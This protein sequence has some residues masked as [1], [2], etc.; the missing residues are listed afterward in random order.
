VSEQDRQPFT[1]AVVADSADLAGP[2]Q[3]LAN[4]LGL[5]LVSHPATGTTT[6]PDAVLRLTPAGLCLARTD[7]GAPA[8]LR[9]DFGSA[10]M[11]HRRRGGQ[12]ELLGRAV[13]VGK[14]ESLRVLDATAGLARDGF[15]LADLGCDVLLCERN[16]VIYELLCDGLR[17]ARSSD[18]PWLAGVTA[19]LSLVPGDAREHPVDASDV[20]YLDPMF[21]HRS[22]RAAVK[23]DL[24]LLQDVLQ[25]QDQQDA[26]HLLT[27][28]L[29][30]DVARVVVK[31][32]LRAPDLVGRSPSHTLRGKA[33]RFDVHVLRG[34]S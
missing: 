10:A 12:N 5:A 25:E 29:Q 2:A 3:N 27:W 22:K 15:V 34:L 33:V 17:R 23:A 32:P 24:A 11:R 8:P 4:R 9:V 18:D 14:R 16:P 6:A 30:Q 31:R 1:L 26:E 20:I 28:A 21:P 19:R 7:Q 13:G